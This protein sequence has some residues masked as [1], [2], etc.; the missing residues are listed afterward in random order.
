LY[1]VVFFTEYV[2]FIVREI[3]ISRSL[4]VWE[5]GDSYFLKYFLLVVG[6]VGREILVW[7]QN[8]F[9]HEETS[10]QTF[11]SFF[12]KYNFFFQKIFNKQLT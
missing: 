6:I 12:N 9:M 3:D 7:I 5:C 10:Q 4:G 11:P 2:N 1:L 8:L